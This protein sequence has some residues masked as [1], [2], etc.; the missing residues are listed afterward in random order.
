MT[1]NRH[2]A[3]IEYIRLATE[4]TEVIHQGNWLPFKEISKPVVS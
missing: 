4:V 3:F 2:V 1:N